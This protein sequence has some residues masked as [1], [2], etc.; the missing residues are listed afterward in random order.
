MQVGPTTFGLA[1][2]Y[3]SEYLNLAVD[4]TLLREV[5]SAT[6]GRYV[7]LTSAS[8]AEIT[9]L[10]SE[11]VA[12]RW[13]VWWPFFLA[14]LAL[15]VVEVAVR[16]LVVPD[17]WRRRWEQLWHRQ[18]ERRDAEPGYEALRAAIARSREEHLA[19]L[20][21]GPY[22]YPENS[23]ARARLYLARFRNRSDV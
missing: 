21:D 9:T 11:G 7:P 16:K 23:A 4:E 22:R 10:E 12:H 1:V 8:L 2:P 6:G 17:E 20:R 14:A 3:S 18:R 19:S 5:A 15:L 13:R